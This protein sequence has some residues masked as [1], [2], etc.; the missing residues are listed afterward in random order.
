MISDPRLIAG[1]LRAE[2]TANLPLP[3]LPEGLPRTVV[4]QLGA[5]VSGAPARAGAIALRHIA[6]AAANM[7]RANAAISVLPLTAWLRAVLAN[8]PGKAAALKASA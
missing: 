4:E 8:A 6:P 2:A 5:G 7:I 1:R 3:Q